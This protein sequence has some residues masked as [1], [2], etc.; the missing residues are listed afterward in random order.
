M[1]RPL[2]TAVLAAILVVGVTGCA[3]KQ[4]HYRWGGYDDAL[5]S[6]YKNPNNHQEYVAALK[7]IILESERAGNKIPPGV[8]AE[9]GYALY[10]EGNASE[11]I[12]YYRREMASW[13]ESRVFMEK[14]IVAAQRQ[15]S[16]GPPGGP[17]PTGPAT[18]AEKASGQ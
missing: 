5:Y 10:E 4:T 8:Y 7:T 11:A 18:A 2:P 15:P 14:M 9:Y 6:H 17:Q 12:G 16:P 1:S 3:S 13:P